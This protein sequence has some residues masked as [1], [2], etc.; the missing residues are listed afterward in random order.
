VLEVKD[1]SIKYGPVQAVRE[2][3]VRVEEGGIVVLLGANGAGKSSLLHCIAGDV[4]ASAGTVSFEQRSLRGLSPERI[5]KLG[6]GL[7][8]EGRWIFG[9]LTVEENLR[10]GATPRKDRANVKR[11]LEDFYARFPAL[12]RYRN[13]NAGKLS[14]GEQQQLAIAR[15]LMGRPRLLMLDEPSLGLAPLVVRGIFEMLTELRSN[16]ITILLVEQFAKSALQ[17][18]DYVFVLAKGRVSKEGVPAEFADPTVLQKS[19]LGAL[20]G[21]QR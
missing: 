21:E 13:S 10:L 18:A 3:S 1:L 11:D 8:P 16:G 14:G 20:E 6:I 7:V 17:V 15:A 9:R 12:G 2:V 4:S 19:Y 5:V